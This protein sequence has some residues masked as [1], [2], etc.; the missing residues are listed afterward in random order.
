MASRS[1]AT[2]SQSA[3]WVDR[4]G[5]VHYDGDPAFGEEWEERV[6]LGFMAMTNEDKKKAYPALLKNALTGRAWTMCQGRPEVSMQRLAEICGRTT[7]SGGD[8]GAHR[9]DL[10]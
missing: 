10:V 5:T 6:W 1:L 9:A 4:D 2:D 3:L 8:A 7:C